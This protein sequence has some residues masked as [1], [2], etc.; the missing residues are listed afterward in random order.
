MLSSCRLFVLVAK[1][2]LNDYLLPYWVHLLSS[3]CKIFVFCQCST[4]EFN[5]PFRSVT[6]R[7]A[8][9]TVLMLWR[10]YS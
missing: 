4:S 6:L 3:Y 2:C 9:H 5:K 8:L 10:S 7:V 1:N